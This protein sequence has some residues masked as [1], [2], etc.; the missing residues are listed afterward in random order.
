MMNQQCKKQPIYH[1]LGAGEFKAQ[2]LDLIAEI[3][4]RGGSVIIH[5][6]DGPAVELTRYVEPPL[7]GYG[8]LKGKV[9][10]PDD[11]E[12]PMPVEWYTDPKVQTDDDWTIDGPMPASWFIDPDAGKPKQ[13]RKPDK[14]DVSV[15]HRHKFLTVNVGE[16]MTQLDEIVAAVAESRY[17]EVAVFDDEK[18]LVQ[19]KRYEEAPSGRQDQIV[20]EEHVS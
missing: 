15:L 7:P 8:I 10:L 3:S 13:R 12:G 17:G 11:I 18:G 20:R 19:L 9:E 14:V 16:F 5:D 2:C 4:K 1:A 6:A